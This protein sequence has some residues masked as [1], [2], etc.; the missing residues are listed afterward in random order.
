MNGTEGIVMWSPERTE[1]LY[2]INTPELYKDELLLHKCN[3]SSFYWYAS[4]QTFHAFYLNKIQILVRKLNHFIS[5]YKNLIWLASK[6]LIK[7][8]LY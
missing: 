8:F 3:L 4:A 2:C 5:F 1:T 6:C 7:S